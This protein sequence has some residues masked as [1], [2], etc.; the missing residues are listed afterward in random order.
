M[1]Q[2]TSRTCVRTRRICRKKQLT[3]CAPL[4]I[5]SYGGSYLPKEPNRYSSKENAQ[6]AHEAIRPSSV[7]VK[8]ADLVNVDQD[9]VRLYDL[10]WSHVSLPAEYDL[11]N[12]TVQAEHYQLKAK[13]R[14][15]RFDERTCVKTCR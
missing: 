1:K 11:V 14:T 4:S 2:V 5:K 9:V 8:V 15:L 6:E 12:L 3:V 10:I 7:A 13:G